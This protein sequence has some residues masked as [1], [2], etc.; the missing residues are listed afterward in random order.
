[1]REFVAR[2][3]NSSPPSS[4]T[5]SPA[6]PATIGILRRKCACGGPAGASSDC[7][8]CKKAAV[9]RSAT[10]TSAG[11]AAPPIVHDVLRS[12]GR[13]LDAATRVDMEPRFG[14]DFSRVRIHAD[15]RAGQSARAVDAFAYTVS[16]NIVFGEGQFAPHSPAG[17]KLLGHELAH[18]VQQQRAATSP[19]S[20]LLI[21]PVNDPLEQEADRRASSLDAPS[22]AM[23]SAFSSAPRRLQRA[24]RGASGPPADA[25]V[26]GG[27]PGPPSVPTP[28]VAAPPAAPA[29]PAAVCGPDVTVATQNVIGAM[30][31]AWGGWDANKKGEACW[32]LEN[33]QCAGEAWD[34]VELHNHAWIQDFRPACAVPPGHKPVCGTT[35][36]V[37]KDCHWAGAVN[38]VIFGR[39][40]N[41]CD[42]WQWTMRQ[43]VRAH[44][45]HV[46]PP[47]ADADYSG[48]MNWAQAGYDGWPGVASPAGDRN[49]CAPTCPTPLGPTANLPSATF[50]FN[51]VP[52]HI[53]EGTSSTCD[54]S[55]EGFR[56]MRD[57]A[58]DFPMEGG[59]GF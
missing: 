47:S 55:V 6:S 24:P 58:A 45:L 8:E 9:Q 56:A 38:Y 28:P 34:I 10:R 41:L 53:T 46:F 7:E 17:R 50:D 25:G 51:W 59:G 35:V 3:E 36:Q 40:C 1:M 26:P 20:D 57:H 32:A 4:A 52:A 11:G 49:D 42:I 37:G 23:P 14:H 30:N 12:P 5:A 15:A 33:L 2:P 22:T 27:A 44:K 39:M 54:E 31:S 18:V 21:G 13:P 48:A 16:N 19:A 29:A 43:L